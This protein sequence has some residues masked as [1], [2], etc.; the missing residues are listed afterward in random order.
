[1]L[2]GINQNIDE[3]INYRFND[4]VI[5]ITVKNYINGSNIPGALLELPMLPALSLIGL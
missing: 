2:N 3:L 1:M 5:L 4:I